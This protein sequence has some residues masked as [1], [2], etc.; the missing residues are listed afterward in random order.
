MTLIQ[1]E[2]IMR[3]D[4][5]HARL[6]HA[7]DSAH[8]AAFVNGRFCSVDTAA[9]PITDV[10]F[11][12][13][14]AAYDVVSAS[15][16]QL[17]RLPDHLARFAASCAAFRLASPYTDEQTTT[18]L[19]RL[20]QLSGTREA[21]VWWCVTRGAMPDTG[22]QRSDPAAYENCFYAFAIPYLF[23]ADDAMR[24]RGLDL[25]VSER[26]IR[27][28]DNAVDPTAKN[29]HWMDMK[30][31]LFEARDRGADFSVLLD[32]AGRV[33]ECPGANLFVV[34]DGAL[35]TPDSG[36]LEGITR[37]TVLELAAQLNVPAH[38]TPV[39]VDWLRGADEAFLTSTAGG[40]MPV[41][42]VDGRVL[43]AGG[44]GPLTTRLHNRYWEQRWAGWHGTP[45]DYSAPPPDLD[46]LTDGRLGL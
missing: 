40:V 3:D 32:G 18:I 14:D 34:R 39:P 10:G 43:G 25:R 2:A 1:A 5:A 33:T 22:S 35:Y 11:L 27:I 46:A 15:A 24:N 9:I 28:P 17:F 31:S 20:L 12:H 36:C 26:Y 29:F 42:S 6:P 4:P 8:G 45:V 16:G 38:V 21:Y 13:A 37:A 41:N 44:P 23:I 7:V 19:T 30:L